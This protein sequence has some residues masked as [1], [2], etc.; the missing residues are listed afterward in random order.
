MNR[1]LGFIHGLPEPQPGS[2]ASCPVD[3]I[4]ALAPSRMSYGRKPLIV[5]FCGNSISL[6][7]EQQA[8]NQ[9]GECQQ[10]G[11]KSN[12]DKGARYKKQRLK[13]NRF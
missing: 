1:V 11:D 9:T 10:P 6:S 2:E 3:P 13:V 4:A 12:E 8:V 5:V 7:R